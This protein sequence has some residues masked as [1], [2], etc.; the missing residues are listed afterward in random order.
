MYSHH[1]G[2][3]SQRNTE[4]LVVTMVRFPPFGETGFSYTNPKAG[5]CVPKGYFFEV[6]VFLIAR[7]VSAGGL[8]GGVA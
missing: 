7:T 2:P 5:G 4:T 8:L 1:K 6:K 3:K